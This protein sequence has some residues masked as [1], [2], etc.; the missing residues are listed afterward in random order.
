MKVKTLSSLALGLVLFA[1][2]KSGEKKDEKQPEKQ[3]APLVLKMDEQTSKYGYYDAE[4]KKV[5]GDYAMAFTD[6]LRDY[7]IVADSGFILIDR[8]GKKVYD[9]FA[10][11]NAPDAPQDGLYRIVKDGKIGYADAQT[12]QVVIAPVYD[13]AYPFGGGKAKVS[14]NC[15]KVQDGEHSSWE[16]DEWMYVDVKGNKV[17]E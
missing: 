3:N 15:K 11:D 14:K 7:A 9:V 16:S 12:H 10:F 2:C 13:C 6:T 17:A 5:L 8:K 4:G 1:G